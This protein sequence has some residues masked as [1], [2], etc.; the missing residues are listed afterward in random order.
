MEIKHEIE[1]KN[2][3]FI[4]IVSDSMMPLLRVNNIYTVSAADLSSIKRFDVILFWYR[5]E[6]T[7]HFYWGPNLLSKEKSF[8][9]KSLKEASQCDEPTDNLLFLG[10]VNIKVSLFHKFIFLLRYFF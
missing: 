4:K 3:Y 10:L 9:T 1:E 8:I 7:A 6:P 5:G 2:L